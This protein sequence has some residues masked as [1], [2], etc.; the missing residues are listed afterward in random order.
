VAFAADGQTVAVARES[1]VLI[2]WDSTKDR[3]QARLDKAPGG[4]TL[5]CVLQ[6]RQEISG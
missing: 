2:L 5:P 3:E 6:G 1:G 4:A